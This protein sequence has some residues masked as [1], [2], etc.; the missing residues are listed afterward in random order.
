MV[1]HT[2]VRTTTY[3]SGPQQLGLHL[4]YEW[5]HHGTYSSTYVRTMVWYTCTY[6]RVR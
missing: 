6:V 5:V 1:L 2:Y 3:N 4:L